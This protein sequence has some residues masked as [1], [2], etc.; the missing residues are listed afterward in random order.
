MAAQ[1]SGM[2]VLLKGAA[3]VI[4][5]FDGGTSLFAAL[6]DRRAPW[7]GTAGA[8]DVLAGMITGLVAGHGARA[9]FHDRI[10]AAA[11]LHAEAARHFGPALIADDIADQIPDVL[12]T[13]GY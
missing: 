12:R 6:Y 7:L 1:R 10:A 3:T 13:L 9:H 11:W 5:S 2:T 4:A 8:G